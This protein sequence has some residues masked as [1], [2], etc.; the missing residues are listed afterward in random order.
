ME[1]L[2]I[3]A[4]TLAVFAVA[5]WMLR[6]EAGRPLGPLA[7]LE[8]V[9]RRGPARSPAEPPSAGR[10][11]LRTGRSAPGGGFRRR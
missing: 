5:L 10:S 7:L 4:F 11:V 1:F 6:A 8:P 9:W 2:L 3:V